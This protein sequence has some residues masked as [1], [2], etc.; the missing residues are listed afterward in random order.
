MGLQS[1]LNSGLSGLTAYGNQMSVIGNNLANSNT[2]GYKGSRTIF[3]DMLSSQVSSAGGSSQIGRGVNTYSV[4]NVFSQG[5]LESTNSPTD[6]AIEGTGFFVVGDPSTEGSYYTRAGSFSF[7]E[8]GYMVN[9][10]GYR[11]QGYQLD[12][13]E[14]AIGTIQDIMVEKSS[15]SPAVATTEIEVSTNLNSDA[16]TFAATAKGTGQ[17][18]ADTAGNIADETF[19]INGNTVDTSTLE[20]GTY[21]QGSAKAIAEEINTNNESGG[22]YEGINAYAS[23]TTVGIGSVVQPAAKVEL[24]G[25]NFKINGEQITGSV[26]VGNATNDIVSLINEKSQATGVTASNDSGTIILQAEDGSNIQ[27]ESSGNAANEDGDAEQMFS[28]FDLTSEHD[29]TTFANLTLSSQDDFNISGWNEAGDVGISFSEDSYGATP[30][31]TVNPGETSN[32]ATSAEIYDSQGN[33]HVLTTYYQKVAENEWDYYITTPGEDV[34]SQNDLEVVGQGH[35]SFDSTGELV[36]I[37]GEE[38]TGD[39]QVTMSTEAIE[40][41]NDSEPSVIQINP[42]LT[43]YSS[44]SLV[45]S[46]QQNGTGPGSLDSISVDEEGYIIGSYANGQTE[47]LAQLSLASFNN[48]EGLKKIG[49]NLYQETLDSGEANVGAPGEGLGSIYSNT[50]EGSNIDIAEQFSK[51]ITSQRAFQANSRTITTTDEMLNE[52]INLKR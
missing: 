32:F 45:Y 26:S 33:T 19:D 52:V 47:A 1:A 6:L 15:L 27:L 42:N 31:D 22:T 28:E 48:N 10:E 46:Q 9:S 7:D 39:G 25:D 35:L 41:A 3:S 14:N 11:V 23:T 8:Q 12:E 2:I 13:D 18:V 16:S 40:W 34:G 24:T 5:S 36:G 20:N 30:F 38:V 4:D 37:N 50:L 49:N 43:Q 29:Q 17:T 21:N 44:E 51:M